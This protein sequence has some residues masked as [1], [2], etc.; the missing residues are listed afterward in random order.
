MLNQGCWNFSGEQVVSGYEYIPK[1]GIWINGCVLRTH[2][3][4]N[5]RS[6]NHVF[7]GFFTLPSDKMIPRPIDVNFLTPW[8]F[9]DLGSSEVIVTNNFKP[10]AKRVSSHS[11]HKCTDNVRFVEITVNSCISLGSRRNRSLTYTSIWNCS[12][13]HEAFC[14]LLLF[15]TSTTQK[16]PASRHNCAL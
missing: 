9:G 16:L 2:C 7:D 8:G 10:R 14:H 11:S 15:H 6:R 1:N 3:K 4:K 5:Y 12:P 13:A